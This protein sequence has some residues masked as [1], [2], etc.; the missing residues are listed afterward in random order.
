MPGILKLLYKNWLYP[1]Y[2][3]QKTPHD[4]CQV[5]VQ[6]QIFKCL[7]KGAS[8]TKVNNQAMFFSCLLLKYNIQGGVNILSVE[9]DELFSA[10]FDF[11][12]LFNSQWKVHSSSYNQYIHTFILSSH[13]LRKMNLALKFLY[14]SI[15]DK[16]NYR[17][18]PLAQQQ[19]QNYP[20]SIDENSGAPQDIS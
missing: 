10:L 7:E 5:A 8:A 16:N 3:V 1:I 2:H 4:L 14:F 20:N 9:L 17:F 11:K 15:F 13:F 12:K 6:L 19:D 18:A